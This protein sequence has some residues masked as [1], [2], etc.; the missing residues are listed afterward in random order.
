MVLTQTTGPEYF[1]EKMKEFR[2]FYVDGSEPPY[3]RG[4]DNPDPRLQFKHFSKSGGMFSSLMSFRNN[5]GLKPEGWI[6]DINQGLFPYPRISCN[7][8]G[9]TNH[10]LTNQFKAFFGLQG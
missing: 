7:Y 2:S 6:E 4:V 10:F 8:I 5:P 3:S 9:F 1:R